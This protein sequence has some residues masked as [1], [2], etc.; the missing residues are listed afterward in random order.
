MEDDRISE[1][2]STLTCLTSND[3]P[4]ARSCRRHRCRRRLILLRAVLFVQE[5]QGVEHFTISDY[6]SMPF[7]FF[8][9]PRNVQITTYLSTLARKAKQTKSNC[10]IG[11]GSYVYYST[12]CFIKTN[13]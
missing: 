12:K 5:D 9:A 8:R 1:L 13:L 10:P 3:V 11:T 4:L 2:S 7:R 6:F